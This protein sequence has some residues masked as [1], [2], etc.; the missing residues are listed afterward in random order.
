MVNEHKY[1]TYDL[2]ED[3]KKLPLI[4]RDHSFKNI[5]LEVLD[6]LGWRM[7]YD[8]NAY[9]IPYFSRSKKSIPFAQWRNLAGSPRFNFLKD[10]K[11]TCYG[12]WN[13]VAP[14]KLFLVEGTSDC[15][16]L[17]TCLVPWIGVPSA[18]S[19][20]LLVSMA[21]FCLRESIQ[22]VYAGDNDD[23]GDKLREALES[24]GPYRVKQPPK[25]YKDWGDF[26]VSE[27]P[28]VVGAYCNEE[29]L[30]ADLPPQ[31]DVEKA[32][33]IFGGELL[34]K[35]AELPMKGPS[36]VRQKLF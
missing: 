6:D 17:Q 2:T 29:I 34:P 15:A 8:R 12:T 5:P 23:A 14:N 21:T 31:S 32:L 16:V 11:P 20:E 4:P 3:W 19:G 28:D 35:D 10:A 22:L 27:G 30:G 1:V 26:Y 33:E 25:K 18:S 7:D 13:L 9:F 24:V 36:N